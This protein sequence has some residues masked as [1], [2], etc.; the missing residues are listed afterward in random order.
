MTTTTQPTKGVTELSARAVVRDTSRQT[1]DKRLQAYLTINEWMAVE[2]NQLVDQAAIDAQNQTSTDARTDD[3]PDLPAAGASASQLS[4]YK[5]QS[6]RATYHIQ[7]IAAIVKELKSKMSDAQ[8]QLIN[9]LNITSLSDIVDHTLENYGQ[10]T[11]KARSAQFEL[12]CSGLP[13]PKSDAHKEEIT[14]TTKT[15]HIKYAQQ[16]LP[17]ADEEVLELVKLLSL[18]KK[19][20]NT[21]SNFSALDTA[22]STMPVN[23]TADDLASTVENVYRN[24]QCLENNKMNSAKTLNPDAPNARCTVHTK[25]KHTSAECTEKTAFKELMAER[26]AKASR[27]RSAAKAK[28]KPKASSTAKD[29][30]SSEEEE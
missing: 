24:Y 17:S 29:A 2:G 6:D 23:Y 15:D 18:T 1:L 12:I 5:V 13:V 27:E 28:P 22:L 3:F 30:E 4:L 9:E 14:A 20:E 11:T 8:I 19:A 25:G 21:R 26:K 10:T 16:C 7:E